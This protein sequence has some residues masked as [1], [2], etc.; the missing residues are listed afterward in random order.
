MSVTR[1]SLLKTALA[2]SAGALAP[3]SAWTELPTSPGCADELQIVS[4][5]LAASVREREL[6]DFGWKFAL[7]NGCD[8]SKDFDFGD[9]GRLNTFAKS[10]NAGLVTTSR[11]DD[12]AWRA[13]DLPHDWAVE[14]PFVND[15]SLV[16]TGSKPLGR[17]YPATSLGW[18]RRSFDV[19]AADEGKRIRLEFDGIMRDATIFLNG[20]RLGENFSGYEPVAFDITDLVEY[21]SHNLVAVRVDA[22]LQE[23]WFYEGAGIYRHVWLTKTSALHFVQH[24]IFVQSEF[25]GNSCDL[26]ISLEVQNATDTSVRCSVHGTIRNARDGFV[27]EV[28]SSLETIAPQSAATILV[29]A[30]LSA[31]HRWSIEDPHLY[32]LSATLHSDGVTVDDDDVRFGVRTLRFDVET[33][34]YLNDKPTKILGTCNHQDHAGVGAAVP[35]RINE[36][37]VE[38]LRAMGSN[39]CR[40]AHNPPASSFL[41]ACDR[42]GMLVMD[43][44]RLFS[45]SPEGLGQLER[46]IRRDR[47][48]PSIILWSIANEEPL[49]GTRIGARMA[50]TMK[51]L[52]HRLDPS[53]PITAAMNA[54]KDWGNGVSNVVDVQGFNYG[55]AADFDAYHHAHPLQPLIGTETASTVSTRGIYVTDPARGYVSAY[56]VNYPEWGAL[57]EEWWPT[58]SSRPW[59][60]G[61]FVWAGFDYRGEPTPYGW[62]CISSHFGIMDTCGFPKDLYFYYKTWWGKEPWLHLFPHWNWPGKEGQPIEVWCYSNQDAI[63]LFLNGRSLGRQVV[64]RDKHLAWKVPYAPGI[65]EARS[66]LGGHPALT[67]RRETTTAPSRLAL[68]SDRSAIFANGADVAV[69]TVRV[70]DAD[71]REI[72]NANNL[73]TFKVTGCGALIGIGNGDPSCHEPDKGNVRSA[74]NGL[75]MG[76]LQSQRNTAGAITVRVS[77]PGLQDATVTLNAVVQN[78]KLVSAQDEETKHEP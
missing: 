44:T 8:S 47:N 34:F 18:Y 11:F 3:K 75:C 15:A 19:A 31:P 76:I 5:G 20:Q 1:R 54:P 36:Y 70:L 2:T 71:S 43:E 46:M 27:A 17:N 37:R 40:T 60:S 78:T 21:G 13:L 41:E 53:R 22:S 77:S 42:L 32:S 38:C 14:L 25:N 67:A 7:G 65:L 73:I 23:G 9:N 56:D 66:Y 35:D 12:S 29:A 57:A 50:T 74:F 63:E 58:Y 52:V 28:R 49:Q 48:H 61:G 64:V 68:A 69:L 72:A 62:P 6:M 4:H 24:G 33:G 45:S 39:A 59:L 30:H 16:N 55:H 10:G 51:R 26:N